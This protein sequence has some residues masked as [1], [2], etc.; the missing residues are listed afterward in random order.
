[1]AETKLRNKD[2][3]KLPGYHFFGQNRQQLHVRARAG[4]GGIGVFVKDEI[5]QQYNVSVLDSSV[6]GIMWVKIASKNGG[7]TWNICVVYL[8]PHGSSRQVDAAAFFE[9]LHMQIFRYQND[10]NF[11]I[12]GDFNSRIGERSDYIEGVDMMEEREVVDT[13]EN[14]YCDLFCDFLVSA[15]CVVLNGR[16]NSLNDFTCVSTRGHSVVDYIVMPHHLIDE[17]SNF[18]VFR[19]SALFTSAQ[20][21]GVIDPT[22]GN[23]PDHSLLKC[24]IKRN[25]N[26]DENGHM[27][28]DDELKKPK[29]MDRK[30]I[31]DNFLQGEV[32]NYIHETITR[33]EGRQGRQ[34]DID[35]AYEQFTSIMKGEMSEKLQYKTV[36][37][38]SGRL[39]KKHRQHKVWWHD[40]LSVLWA[41]LCQA[42]KQWLSAGG[43]QKRLRQAEMKTIQRQF[44]REVQRAKRQH[45][46]RQ[47]EEML[48]LCENNPQTFWKKMGHIGIAQERTRGIP[49]EVILPNGSVSKDKQVVL[50]KWKD[51][52]CDLLN[53][54]SDHNEPVAE[55]DLP[56]YPD[57]EIGLDNLNK[58][59]SWDEVVKA[60]Q[61]AKLGK[62]IGIDGLPTEV[63]R[64]PVCA[65]FLVSLFNVCF[66]TGQMPS[67]WNKS[68][69]TPVH[70]D[71]DSDIR[72]P[73]N[74]R[75][76][77][78]TSS[79]YKVYCCIINVRVSEWVEVN[80]FLQDEQN[81]FRKSRSTVDQLLS[82]TN[83]VES[84]KLK[85]LD[86][87]VAFID[88]SKAYDHINR[89]LLWQKLER[90]GL[91]GNIL[92]AMKSLYSDVRCCVKLGMG[93]L[94][95]EW[96]K[97]N[98]GLRQGC[99]ISPLM[100]NI[101]INDL[102]MV[103][104]DKCKGVKLENGNELCLL[105][106]ADDIVFLAET[107]DDLQLML[108]VL[109]E[110]CKSWE[111]TVNLKKS[112]I[113]HFRSTSKVVTE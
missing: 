98:S 25:S 64:N 16:K 18:E 70:K 45:W 43:N 59:I 74:H 91:H 77:A 20:C 39:R 106:Y 19:A 87:F 54:D 41:Q 58:D 37:I 44:Q 29:V 63:L 97:V 103:I 3:I 32:I 99:L 48:T 26:N 109:S 71:K 55:D 65:D 79:V 92:N 2:T 6:E 112:Q 24:Y 108:N 31:P 22:T 1:M 30:H 34:E 78:I 14:A 95:T 88:F 10:G 89:S 81:G 107:E 21:T 52:F 62:A 105:M 90:L 96:F 101:Y 8:P 15:N 76:I 38:S 46:Y 51:H 68:V 83:V 35:E 17:Y 82:F 11:A 104:K 69:I 40:G 9:D 28:Q 86:T 67:Q 23:L 100:F 110:W 5:M 94:C 27:D 12:V 73:G 53:V 50:G 93:S 84:R 47:Q 66:Q 33:L 36:H 102:A 4:S 111:V 113:M 13:K 61:Q 60:L 42:E 72:D 85:R 75:G 49:L 80:K 57:P 7:L 56:Q